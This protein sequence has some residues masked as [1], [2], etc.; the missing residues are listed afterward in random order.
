M[1]KTLEFSQLL[2][3]DRKQLHWF[4]RLVKYAH[5]FKTYQQSQFNK[6]STANRSQYLERQG[7]RWRQSTVANVP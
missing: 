5:L 1:Y 7:T 6:H 4:Q 2:T 3:E